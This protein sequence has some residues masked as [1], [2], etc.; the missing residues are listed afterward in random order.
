[1]KILSLSY[2]DNALVWSLEKIVF[3][4]LTLLVGASGVGKT[5]ILNS[6]LKLKEIANGESVSGVEWE[7][8]FETLDK[9]IF[10][11]TGA[12]ISQVIINV[13]YADMFGD[14]LDSLLKKGVSFN[15]L[16]FSIVTLIVFLSTFYF[17]KQGMEHR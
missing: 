7:I 8:E 6:I 2:T 14:F 15:W 4:N 17:S 1:M 13:I 10:R 5:Q 9:H 3:E 11:W 12:T 16:L